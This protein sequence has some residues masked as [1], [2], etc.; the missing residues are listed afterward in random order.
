[1]KTK[2]SIKSQR[3]YY[4]SNEYTE[5]GEYTVDI[6]TEGLY[7]LTVIGGGG[8]CAY[9]DGGKDG[10]SD[11]SRAW[12]YGHDG[13]YGSSFIGYANLTKGTLTITVGVAGV[14]YAGQGVATGHGGDSYVTFTPENGEP[15]EIIRAG[16]GHSGF[17]ASS[18][19]ANVAGGEVTY[20]P[21]YIEKVVQAN[22][23]ADGTLRWSLFA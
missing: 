7:K 3:I 14:N 23:G 20:D 13:G 6:V 18:F 4:K 19:T 5:A 1:M 12:H 16:G 22:K 9:V 21:T 8:G 10:Y 11:T 2:A 17:H 15:V